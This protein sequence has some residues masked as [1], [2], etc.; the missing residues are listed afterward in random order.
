MIKLISVPVGMPN[1]H[2]I[3]ANINASDGRRGKYAPNAQL[4]GLHQCII[5]A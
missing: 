1:I 4:I 2:R 5:I 3:A